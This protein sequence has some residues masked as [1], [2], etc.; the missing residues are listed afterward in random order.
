MKTELENEAYDI[1]SIDLENIHRSTT[2][3]PH[4]ISM[5]DNSQADEIE[6]FMT[7][8]HPAINRKWVKVALKNGDRCFTVKLGSEIAG[9]G[10]VSLVNGIGRLHSLYVKPQFRK[11]RAW[12]T[13]SWVLGFFGS[14]RNMPVLYFRRF[15]ASTFRVRE[16]QPRST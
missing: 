12:A 8:T 5:A 13:T 9:V 10:W 7:L 4:E 2:G 11:A 16:S 1:Y 3:S 14:S 6:R 15:P